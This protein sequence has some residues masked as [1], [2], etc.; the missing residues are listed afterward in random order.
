MND[1]QNKPCPFCGELIKPEALKCR[2]CGEFLT[3]A[4]VTPPSCTTSTD[5]GV[6]F[7]GCISRLVLVGPT[8]TAMF[9]IA[10]AC[11]LIFVGG[12]AIKNPTLAKLPL[13][14]GIGI[15]VIALINCL[16]RWLDVM[17]R[18]YHVTRDRIEYEH[19]IFSKTVHNVDLWRVLD[20]SF[21]ASFIQRLF[22]LG[23]VRVTTSDKDT[24]FINIG[25]VPNARPLYDN[26][27]KAQLTAD[28]RRGVLHVEP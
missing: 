14:I 27:K 19:G 9:W 21:T 8:L 3:D 5:P 15:A 12:P 6:F 10:M 11:L 1:P 13:P 17:S 7:S 16:I 20:I 26:L 28:R 4:T 2:F 22:R 23:C 25:P 24:P 18:I